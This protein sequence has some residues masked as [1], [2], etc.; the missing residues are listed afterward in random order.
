MEQ[1][2]DRIKLLMVYDNLLTLTENIERSKKTLLNEQPLPLVIKTLKGVLSAD[3]TFFNI[4][5]T[6]SSFFRRFSSADEMFKEL[7]K[8][9]KGTSS[10][11]TRDLT[12]AIKQI[13]GNSPEFLIALEK[14]LV[15]SKKFKEIASKAYPNGGSGSANKKMRD[16]IINY[17]EQ[18]GLK[19][20][21]VDDLLKRN[22]GKVKNAPPAEVMKYWEGFKT[23]WK[24][25]GILKETLKKAWGK[26][27]RG[28]RADGMTKDQW[29]RLGM[30]AVTGSNRL[31]SQIIS[32]FRRLGFGPGVASFG[33]EVMK[34][35][36]FLFSRLTILN[37]LLGILIDVPDKDTEYGPE[38]S[39]FDILYDRL[40]KA[41]TVPDIEW[42]LPMFITWDFAGKFIHDV[43]DPLA[44]G[45]SVSVVI[46]RIKERISKIEP[47]AQ[48]LFDD[49][50][51]Q[52]EETVGEKGLQLFLKSKGKEYEPN[53][54]K[55]KEGDYPA[56]GM[57]TE[58]NLYYFEDNK[59]SI[60][61]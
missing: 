36:W 58:G 1:T 30:W 46:S 51:K 47:E 21:R 18:I 57:D 39:F 53:S 17:Y 14:E 35:W 3:R 6:E 27:I 25:E 11:P 22:A 7:E 59:W 9:Q 34:R 32:D 56:E 20:D 45:N 2:L 12:I 50:Q 4:L 61:E 24:S 33:G 10:I 60:V 13:V 43:L 41:W 49:S 54:F 55:P 52:V 40:K 31:P 42:V 5:K 37:L 44:R 19:P 26:I 48:K 38:Y 16:K 28:S 8:I 29:K 15:K 23:G